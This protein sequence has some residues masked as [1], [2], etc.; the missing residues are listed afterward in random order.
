M[1]T[2]LPDEFNA[3]YDLIKVTRDDLEAIYEAFATVYKSPSEHHRPLDARL[4]TDDNERWFI[5]NAD[6]FNGLLEKC[7]VK[8]R[9]KYNFTKFTISFIID[10][11][12]P[13]KMLIIY[14]EA[15]LELSESTATFYISR[16]DKPELLEL[17]DTVDGILNNRTRWINNVNNNALTSFIIAILTVAATFLFYSMNRAIMTTFDIFIVLVLYVV[18]AL[19]FYFV[20]IRILYK[21]SHVKF[22]LKSKSDLPKKRFAPTKEEII[23]GIVLAI[24]GGATTWLMPEILKRI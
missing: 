13:D 20:L 23:W 2:R 11:N 16:L 19:A 8:T 3:K 17:R 15:K 1:A 10:D 5:W 24:I 14:P 12:D 4:I 6:D 18:L 22:D 7:D 9:Q 21:S